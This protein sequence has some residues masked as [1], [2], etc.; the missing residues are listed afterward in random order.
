MCT[1][2]KS[3][4]TSAQVAEGFAAPLSEISLNEELYTLFLESVERQ[5][6]YNGICEDGSYE[7][8]LGYD[9]D[10]YPNK[11]GE[12]VT[13]PFVW[14]YTTLVTSLRARGIIKTS[15][16]Y[17]PYFGLTPIL[18]LTEQNQRASELRAK[19]AEKKGDAKKPAAPKTVS[20]EDA[21]F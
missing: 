6:N 9:A 17:G 8:I 1:L 19:I 5:P 21:A 13:E 14:V 18:S 2:Y 3:V 10:G 20:P 7:P 15:K 4:L 16:Q 11:F 12:T